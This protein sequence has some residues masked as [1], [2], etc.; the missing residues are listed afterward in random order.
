[1]HAYASSAKTIPTT[2]TALHIFT[3]PSSM[4]PSP[5]A[6]QICFWRWLLFYSHIRHYFPDCPG[7]LYCRYWL[8]PSW[9]SH[10]QQDLCRPPPLLAA[11]AGRKYH[12]P[13]SMSLRCTPP[14]GAFSGLY[15]LDT[16][17][18]GFSGYQ[19]PPWLS[20]RIPFAL[21]GLVLPLVTAG[22]ECSVYVLSGDVGH[23]RTKK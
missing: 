19:R 12:C 21:A 5:E 10:P 3:P 18:C 14:Q 9:E 17:F 2:I 8:V 20:S 7:I 16:I 6:E 23:A 4:S 13:L 15:S 22:R 1:M 11:K